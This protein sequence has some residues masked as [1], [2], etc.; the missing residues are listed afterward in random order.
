MITQEFRQKVREAILLDRRNYGGSDA[1]YAKS[2]GID[3]TIYSRIKN[4][5]TEKVAAVGFWIAQGRRLDVTLSSRKWNVART[6]V[7]DDIEDN[8]KFCQSHHKATILIDD[9]GIGKTFC[10]KHI[11]KGRQNAFYFDCSQ[12]KTK[13]SF[14]RQL[15]KT[16]GLDAKGR[17]LEIKENLKYYLNQM[18]SPFIALDDAGYLDN[19]VLPEIIEIWNATQFNCGWMM[20]GDDSLQSKIERGLQHKKI[21]YKALFSRFSEEF[22]HYVPLGSGDKTAFYRQLIGDVADVNLNNKALTNKMIKQCLTKG[23]T[24]RYLETLIQLENDEQSTN[25][26]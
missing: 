9:C 25:I 4:G 11:I 14:V 20:I 3:K 2:L 24:L 22:I 15:A 26:E 16:V 10:T 1:A 8:I 18:Q 12:A 7:Y 5:E 23:K 17:Y 6:T 19:S 21:G 13:M